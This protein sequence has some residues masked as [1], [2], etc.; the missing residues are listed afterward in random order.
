MLQLYLIIINNKHNY[1][2]EQISYKYGKP[3]KYEPMFEYIQSDATKTMYCNY[4]VTKKYYSP[5]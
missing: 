4:E 2:E 1:P 3:A 5:A